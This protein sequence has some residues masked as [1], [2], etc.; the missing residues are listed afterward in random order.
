MDL[1]N[2]VKIPQNRDSF[3]EIVK[4]NDWKHTIDLIIKIKEIIDYMNM[5]IIIRSYLSSIIYP[6]TEITIKI[7]K[8]N[9]TVITEKINSSTVLKM[10]YYEFQKWAQYR[11]N[12]DLKYYDDSSFYCFSFISNPYVVKNK[13]LFYIKPIYPWKESLLKEVRSVEN[14][15]IVYEKIIEKQKKKIYLLTK[16][17]IQ[18]KKRKNTH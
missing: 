12:Y 14:K 18:L 11:I 7:K 1:S 15:E 4:S 2:R 9:D 8:N 10:N 16:K 6:F 13:D 3:F 5:Y 17:I